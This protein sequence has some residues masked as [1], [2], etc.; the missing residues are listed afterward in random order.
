MSKSTH[1]GARQGAGRPRLPSRMLR[2][3]SE[4][5]AM[6]D[7]LQEFLAPDQTV[8]SFIEELI[9]DKFYQHFDKQGIIKP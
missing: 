2:I 5:Y 7:N 3:D 9:R 6:A 8:R 1:G 4:V